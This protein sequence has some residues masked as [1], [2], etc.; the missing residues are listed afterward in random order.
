M[1]VELVR[2]CYLGSWRLYSGSPEV[3]VRGRYF[4]CGDNTPFFPF[5]H[6]Y[7]SADWHFARDEYYEPPN[8]GEI[9]TARLGWSGGQLGIALP[10]AN[11]VGDEDCFRRGQTYPHPAVQRTLPAGVDSR[12]WSQAGLPVPIYPMG[13]EIVWFRPEELSV[14]SGGGNIPKWRDSSPYQNHLVQATTVLQPVYAASQINGLPGVRFTAARTLV[15]GQEPTVPSAPIV[16]G[17]GMSVYVVC[18]L[19]G[20]GGLGGFVLTGPDTVGTTQPAEGL[21]GRAAAVGGNFSGGETFQASTGLTANTPHIW[22]LRREA[23]AVRYYVDG[24]LV[25]VDEI[26]VTATAA[27]TGIKAWPFGIPAAQNTVVCEVLAYAWQTI[28]DEHDAILEYL[29][30]KYAI[31]LNV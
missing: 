8:L 29:S 4:F 13:G 14:Y 12:V 28:E 21:G 27:L 10:P 20:S 23:D 31:P 11:A 2:S 18:K 5:P 19:Q 24:A 17:P 30:D 22:T 26:N 25:L 1:A 3:L 16:F 9:R 15:W 7:W 6:D